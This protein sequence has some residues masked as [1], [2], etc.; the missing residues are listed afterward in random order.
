MGGKWKWQSSIELSD[1]EAVRDLL[2]LWFPI[3]DELDNV[4]PAFYEIGRVKIEHVATVEECGRDV[5]PEIG[6]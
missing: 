5:L 3:M 2:H 6:G 4:C 1:L